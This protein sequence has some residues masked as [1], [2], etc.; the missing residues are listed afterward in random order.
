MLCKVRNSSEH[1][2]LLV[3]KLRKFNKFRMEG[4]IAKIHYIHCS[5]Q[6]NP[7]YFKS[8]VIIT[9]LQAGYAEH[10]V[11][12]LCYPASESTL[13]FKKLI[14]KASNFILRIVEFTIQV[15]IHLSRQAQFTI[16]DSK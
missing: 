8:L 2:E 10:M 3:I 5:V 9:S 7:S 1:Q 16:C 14:G 4:G 6:I 15:S 13:N 11:Y 12:S